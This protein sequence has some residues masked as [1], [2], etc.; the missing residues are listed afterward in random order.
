MNNTKLIRNIGIVSIIVGV[1]ATVFGFK[2]FNDAN[3]MVKALEDGGSLFGYTDS[4]TSSIDLWTSRSNNY[5]IVMIV[6]AVILLVGVIMFFSALMS[7]QKTSS[8]SNTQNIPQQHNNQ[9]IEDK[10]K[11]LEDLKN[12]GIIT[13]DEYIEQRKRMLSEL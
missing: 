2:N 9:N 4:T 6:G 13:E 1:I 5:K 11:N 3:S 10:L 7:K 8:E 12:R